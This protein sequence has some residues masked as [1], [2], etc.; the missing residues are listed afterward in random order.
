MVTLR[1]FQL[2]QLEFSTFSSPPVRQADA[3]I[4]REPCPRLAPF[5]KLRL[6]V[7][8]PPLTAV[9]IGVR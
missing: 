8:K 1:Q 7:E 2:L 4:F 6:F 5:A 9:A 3:G